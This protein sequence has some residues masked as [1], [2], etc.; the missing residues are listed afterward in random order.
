MR[1][2]VLLVGLW[3]LAWGEVTLANVISGVV[4]ASALLLAFPPSSRAGPRV[5][6]RPGGV[7]RLAAYVVIQLVSS[8][9]VMARVICRRRPALRP[10]V[11]AHRLHRPSEEIVTVMTSVIALSPGTMTVDVDRDSTTIYVHF[12]LLGDVAAARASLARLEQL[13]VHA[14]AVVDEAPASPAASASQKESP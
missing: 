1:R 3:L 11:L 13:A 7:A 10:G 9:V 12:L 5:R 6:V 14:V 2:I 8:N 4:V